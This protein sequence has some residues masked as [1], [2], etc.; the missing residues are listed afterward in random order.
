MLLRMALKQTSMEQVKP[1]PPP[2]LW[3]QPQNWAGGACLSRSGPCH[4]IKK[5]I[6]VSHP[7]PM[8]W[9]TGQM[10]EE[11]PPSYS[12]PNPTFLWVE[13]TLS[14]VGMKFL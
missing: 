1:A 2:G 13:K 14:S 8:L 4:V 3:R 7:P 11:S 5:N 12:V 9:G 6:A 10:L